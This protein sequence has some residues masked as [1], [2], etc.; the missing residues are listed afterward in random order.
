MASPSEAEVRVMLQNAV[1][2]LEE[3]R[4]FASV[5]ASNYLGIE[6]T[7]TQALEGDYMEALL[8]AV[9]SNRG[10]LAGMLGDGAAI[11]T[12]II[13]EYGRIINAP[14]QEIGSILARLYIYF[15]ANSFT[16]KTRAFTFGSPAAAGGNV[17]TGTIVRSNKG[18]DGDDIESQHADAKIAT[19]VSDQNTG[20]KKHKEIFQFKGGDRGPDLLQ[21]YD[22]GSGKTRTVTALSTQESLMRNPSFHLY[23]GSAVGIGNMTSLTGWTLASGLI[24]DAGVSET[25]AN[26]YVT[27]PDEDVARSLMIDNN[28]KFTQALSLK[29]T[30]LERGRP[31]IWQIAYNRQIGAGTMDLTIRVGSNASATVSLAAQTGWQLLR[32]TINAN[33]WPENFEQDAM[34]I[35]IEIS[36]Y[37]AGFVILDNFIFAPMENFDNSWYAIFGGQT[38]FLLDDEFTWTDTETGAKIQRWLHR[39]FNFFLPHD[40]APTIADP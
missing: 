23:V 22:V 20:Q 33:L 25:A 1:N 21:S 17:G 38:P 16:V 40:A 2:L 39:A 32:P 8:R 6:D 13:R 27:G 31:Y 3:T 37:A 26:I 18:Y 34:D 11:L 19:C 24:T 5:N 29:N 4:K 14:E 12:P 15:V 36:N 7:L 35:E 9:K 30:I 28:L 10:K